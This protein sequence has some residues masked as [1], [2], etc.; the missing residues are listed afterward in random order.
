MSSSVGV[1]CAVLQALCS[2]PGSNLQNEQC[3]EGAAR[4]QLGELKSDENFRCG[5]VEV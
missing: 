1:G 5:L 4:E 2:P 3:N